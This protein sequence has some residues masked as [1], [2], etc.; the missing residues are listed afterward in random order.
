MSSSRKIGVVTSSRADY[1]L[2][3]NL[4]L[5]IESEPNLDLFLFVTGSH[6]SPEFGNTV[7]EII[8]DGLKITKKLEIIMSSDSEAS[9]CKSLGLAM[10]SFSDCFENYKPD[11]LLILGDRYEMMA[12][13]C[14]ALI[15][16]IPICHI[17]GGE[18]T[19]GG[20]DDAIRHSITKMSHWHF[21]ATDEYANRV[22]QLG[23]NPKRVF[24]V[25]GMGVDAIRELDLLNKEDLQL[26]LKFKFNKRNLIVTYHPVTLD[27]N[28]SQKSFNELLKS[29]AK[30][31]DTNIIFTFANA[32]SDGK[33]INE[34]IKKYVKKN[35]NSIYFKSLGQLLYFS[36]LQYVDAIVGNSSSGLLEGPSFKIGTINI[37]DR[38]NGRI[39]SSSVINCSP[40]AEKISDS[41][42]ILYTQEFQMKLK[43]VDNPYGK[44]EATNKILK[45]I[46]NKEL[47]INTK[48]NFFDI[49]SNK[50]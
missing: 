3:K 1:G 35:R 45:I 12:A 36:V 11:L 20:Y 19:K 17:H 2:L 40:V 28:S 10:I 13:S 25:G 50:R 24:N 15:M 41:F 22:I 38:Q 34:M 39:K 31:K 21:V 5:K 49:S 9:I 44:G 27:K 18:K 14:S 16:K 42:K 26:A 37:G 23:E 7:E 6:L 47:P 43:T 8:I 48:K 4:L 46:K 32:D 29:L 33:V 30:L